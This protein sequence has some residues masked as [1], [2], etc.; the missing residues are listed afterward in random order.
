MPMFQALRLCPEAVVLRGRMDVYAE[1][2]AQIRVMMAELTPAVEP[3]SLDE[4]FLDLSGTARLHGQPPAVLLAGLARRIQ[5]ELGITGSIGLSHNKFLAKL[6]SDLDKPRGFSV[7]GRGETLD[8]L[9]DKPVRM[10]WGI[11]AAGQASLEK[12]GIRTIS[13]LRRWDRADLQARFGAMGDRLWHL[14]RGQDLRRVAPDRAIK[15]I[16]SETTF[17]EDTSDPDLLDGHIWRLAE[18]I[19]DRAKAKDLA[20]RVVTLKLKRADFRLVTRRQSLPDGTQIA[21]RIYR[22]AR[23]LFDQTAHAQA[24]RLIGLGLSEL[25]P[26]TTAD[27]S[28]DLLDPDQARRV[29]AERATDA[30]RARFGPDA[31]LKGRALR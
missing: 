12:V 5:R 1:V 10:I 20:G 29:G 7:I 11:G 26:A 24:Y 16:S 13:D 19:A 6:A 31:I 4:A 27:R 23:L 30:I 8:F 21:D 22:T 14:A 28:G 18:K 15:S 17:S 3:L 25:V 9:R 2:S